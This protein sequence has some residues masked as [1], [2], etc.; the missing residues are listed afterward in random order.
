M[1]EPF[2]AAPLPTKALRDPRYK[3]SSLQTVPQLLHQFPP[4]TLPVSWDATRDSRGEV[5][6]RALVQPL[7]D[8]DRH[9]QSRHH[10]GLRAVLDWL[11]EFPGVTWQERFLDSIETPADNIGWKHAAAQWWSSTRPEPTTVKNGIN[12]IAIGTASLICADVLRPPVD[13][14]M[15][16]RTPKNLA[17]RLEQARDPHGW[18][19]LR[20]ACDADPAGR[21]TKTRALCRIAVIMAAKGG[22]VADITVGD[23]L[24]L[25]Q[26]IQRIGGG[27]TTTSGYFY[28]LLRTIGVLGADAPS[29]V[30]VFGTTGQVSV[31]QLIDR[32]GISCRPV[33]DLLV[34]YL[35]ERQSTVDYVTLQRL[36]G[37]LGKLFWADLEHHHP[38]IDSPR[39]APR[40]PRPGSSASSP[41]SRACPPWRWCGRSIWTSRSG[42]WKNPHDGVR[43]QRRARS[44]ATKCRG[45]KPCGSANPAWISAPA[46]DFLSC[47]TLSPPST[48]SDARQQNCSTQ[49]KLLAPATRSPRPGRPYAAASW[50]PATV[51]RRSGPRT[52]PAGPD[53]T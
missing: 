29:T 23:C 42:R 14:L 33:R 15:S 25:L 45:R 46:N 6:A 40:S 1:I 26:A 20:A 11:T 49:P 43:G 2:I 10:R 9:E 51:A 22:A 39:L 4:R 36:A 44:A 34:D 5:L 32:Y 38:G 28:H 18:A 41:E 19:A 21:S 35:R 47:P 24:E 17:M 52:L 30:R 13:W 31:E 48:P 27:K 12:L 37:T 50:P 3:P 53:S 8:A 16:P 7:L